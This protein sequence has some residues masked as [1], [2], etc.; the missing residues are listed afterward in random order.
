MD[1]E[2]AQDQL[3]VLIAAR[4]DKLAGINLITS[5]RF[6]R[7]RAVLLVE[8][9]ALGHDS[10]VADVDGAAVDH[11]PAARA[12]VAAEVPLVAGRLRV[13]DQPAGRLD[14]ERGGG[15]GAEDD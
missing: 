11:A 6:D 10:R 14:G 4:E 9:E 13:E 1:I 7:E 3:P 2:S 15:V 8:L 12:G 5:L